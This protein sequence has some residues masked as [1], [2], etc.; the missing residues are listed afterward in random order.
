MCRSYT[1]LHATVKLVSYYYVG[2]DKVLRSENSHKEAML[3]SAIQVRKAK[4][5]TLIVILLFIRRLQYLK[6]V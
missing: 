3:K 1:P 5:T 4:L 6:L 2:Q